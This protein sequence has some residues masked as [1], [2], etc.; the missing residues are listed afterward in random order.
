MVDLACFLPDSQ[1]GW[2]PGA[3]FDS[4]VRQ[5]EMQAWGRPR[6]VASALL[7]PQKQHRHLDAVLHAAGRGT[8]KKIGEEAMP[9]SAHG[10]QVTAFALYPLDNLLHRLAICQSGFGGDAE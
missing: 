7:R 2:R 4:T 10:H 8:E 3:I 6:S 5:R 1:C 9:V